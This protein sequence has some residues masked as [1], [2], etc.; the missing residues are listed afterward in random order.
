MHAHSGRTAIPRYL[1][2]RR[3]LYGGLG[4]MAGSAAFA[5]AC[6]GSDKEDSKAPSGGAAQGTT[7]AASGGQTPKRGG[8]L[9]D[10]IATDG[11]PNVN[12][13]TTWG[14][15]Q[16]LSGAYVYDRLVNSR[17]GKDTARE[18]ILEAAQS[19][20]IPEPLTLTFKLKPGMKFQ[21]RAPI[22]GRDVTADD[23]VKSQLYVR[24]QVAAQDRSFQTASMQS[25][26]APDAQTVVFKL[27]APNAYV[28]SA[29]QLTY[30]QSTCII[31][32]ENLDKL[33]TAWPVGSG[34]Y[35][36]TD[37]N[38][39]VRYAFKRFEGFR[40]AGKGMPFIDQREA[41]LMVD[42]AAQEASFRSEQMH[43]WPNIPNPTMA[44]QIKRDL[45][46]KI[47][48]D[49]YQTLSPFP[50][51]MNATKPPFNDP[52]VRE[53]VY[54]AL[55]RQQYLDLL[56]LGRGVLPAGVLSAG[57]TE[58][59]LDPKQTEKYWKNDPRA[60]RQLLEA[61]GYDFGKEYRMLTL[62]RPKNNQGG[63]IFAQQ[64]SQAGMKIRLLAPVTLGDWHHHMEN[65]DFDVAYAAMPGYDS[66]QKVLRFQHSN[67]LSAYKYTGPKDSAIDAMIE[68][69]EVTLDKNERIKQVKDIQV[70]LLEKYT[71]FFLTH[72]FK[73]YVARW[74]Y[75]KDY[76][77]IASS[78]AMPRT[79]LWMDRG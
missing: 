4:L 39:G 60:A 18:Y 51:I 13:V 69:S 79:E 32:K 72:N 11:S 75:V 54:R 71:P 67:S 76:E 57:L 52:R 49:E 8:A 20:E 50:V 25:V 45:G 38:L 74:K 33:D 36:L 64:V 66:P 3:A 23:V 73:A 28:F 1:S 59:Q 24:D 42:P 47:V 6:G 26:E 77:V 22:S 68:K 7:A 34:P 30:P 63:E 41:R 2:R 65:G 12:P 17:I 62:N 78:H 44:D 46:D 5:L 21:N 35:E 10:M 9:G 19:V 40:E 29:T 15:G 56:D 31:P 48:L 43:I 16:W 55:N 14:E 53:A 70:A 58:Y 37:Y 27:K 61:A